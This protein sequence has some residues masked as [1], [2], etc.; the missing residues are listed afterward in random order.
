MTTVLELRDPSPV[1]EIPADA[2]IPLSRLIRVEWSK[3]TDTRSARWL[4]GLAGIVSVAALLLPMLRTSI[5]QTY[6]QYL[7]FAGLGTSLLLPIVPIMTMTGE[8]SQRS[9]MTF[10]QEPRRARVVQAKIIV[11]L[12]MSAIAVVLAAAFCALGIAIVAATGRGVVD[13]LG[14][15]AVI[16]FV[17]FVLLNMLMGVAFAAS[18][19]NTAAAIVQFILLPTVAG[20]VGGFVP[21]VNDWLDP[22]TTFIWVQQGQWSG[23]VAQIAV[24]IILWVAAPLVLGIVRTTRREI[25]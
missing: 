25:K 6:R 13:D 12:I 4:I 23:H 10:L 15:A 9:V 11:S 24:S 14:A 1:A 8:W 22:N 21:W 17:L 20:I 2:P 3:A 7:Q 16:G 5:D 18:L 19:H